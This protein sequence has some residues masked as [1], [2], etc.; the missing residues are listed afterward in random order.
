MKTMM[1][2]PQ[3]MARKYWRYIENFTWMYEGTKKAQKQSQVVK[4][5]ILMIHLTV[6]V[7]FP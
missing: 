6:P 4:N 2:Y 5:Q 3:P 1:E 7:L